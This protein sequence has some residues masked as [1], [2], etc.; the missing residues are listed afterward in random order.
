MCAPAPAVVRRPLGS[1]APRRADPV[2]YDAG[3]G[4]RAFL[5]RR[6]GAEPVARGEMARKSSDARAGA[7]GEEFSARPTRQRVKVTTTRDD[8]VGVEIDA[9]A[10]VGGK[11]HADPAPGLLRER[12]ASELDALRGLLRKAELLCRGKKSGRRLATEPRSEALMEADGKAP[13]AKRMRVDPVV[14]QIEAPRTPPPAESTQLDGD[15]DPLGGGGGEMAT[16]DHVSVRDSVMLEST[17]QQL[18]KFAEESKIKVVPEEEEDEFADIL[19]G[20]SPVAIRE[21]S[22]LVLLET[23]GSSS[24]S[25]SESDSDES[26][27]SP[28]PAAVLAEV[29]KS[30][31]ALREED[32]EFVDICGGVSPPS[33]IAIRDASPLGSPEKAG[34]GGNSPSSS[35]D[36][37][38][39]SSSDS[40]DDD[41]TASSSGAESDE[42]VNSPAPAAVLPEESATSAQALPEAALEAVRSAAAE[43]EKR[44]DVAAAAPCAAKEK[45]QDT[46][47]RAAPTAS[48]MSVLLV[49]AR[50]AQDVRRRQGKGWEREKARRALAEVERAAPPDERI[51]P[52]DM[53]ELGIATFEY[54]VSTARPT[55]SGGGRRAPR[56]RPSLLQRL[57]VFLK[58]DA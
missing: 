15:A 1:A 28:A 8:V 19:D 5:E 53:R 3:S 36:S 54:I 49:K 38:S 16:N 10:D 29:G 34:A 23:A 45:P 12:L 39:S 32:E 9:A 25:G 56:G 42:S 35:G 30:T 11:M 55:V 33:P 6:W 41:D 44:L 18:D 2:P 50:E 21:A 46:I 22:P 24:D 37:G 26:V 14:H 58:P 27:D 52:R 4:E 40:D 51:H 7:G 47:Q 57:G 20:V 43:P 13:A 31:P 17:E 48:R